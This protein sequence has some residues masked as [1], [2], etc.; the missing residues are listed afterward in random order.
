[1]FVYYELSYRTRR[2]MLAEGKNC[3]VPK[4]PFNELCTLI[5]NAIN[6]VSS[7]T[8]IKTFKQK[9]LSLPIDGSRDQEEGGKTLPRYIAEPQASMRFQ[10]SIDRM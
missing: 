9:L 3:P 6:S 7:E 8:I 5:A 1:M 2:L 10:R 4:M